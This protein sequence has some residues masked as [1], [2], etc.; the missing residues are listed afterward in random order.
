VERADKTLPTGK[1]VFRA[2]R[3]IRVYRSCMLLY[4]MLLQRDKRMRE[5]RYV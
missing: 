1:G 3:D 4:L 2:G 5:Y